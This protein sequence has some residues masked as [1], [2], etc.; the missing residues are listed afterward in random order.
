MCINTCAFSSFVCVLSSYVMSLPKVKTFVNQAQS[1]A[2]RWRYNW[3]YCYMVALLEQIPL[4]GC[5]I[6]ACAVGKIKVAAQLSVQSSHFHCH[7]EL[8]MS[9]ALDKSI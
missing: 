6:I 1:G 8:D 9:Q 3:L 4:L 5:Q 2:R 7:T